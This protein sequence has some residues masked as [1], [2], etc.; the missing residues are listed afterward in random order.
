[1]G[2]NILLLLLYICQA[3][4]CMTLMLPILLVTICILPIWKPD[5][6]TLIEVLE[7]EMFPIMIL[8]ELTTMDDKNE[9]KNN[10]M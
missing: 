2:N 9:P 4:Y 3:T 1:M 8:Y 6:E 7:F 5:N 10:K